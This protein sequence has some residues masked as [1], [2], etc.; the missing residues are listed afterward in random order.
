MKTKIL[1]LGAG[2]TTVWAYRHLLKNCNKSVREN[3]SIEI[4]SVSAE[5]AFH[6]FTGEFL[7]GLL[8]LKLR[9]TSHQTLFPEAHFIQGFVQKVNQI[10]Q[11]VYYFDSKTQ[12]NQVATYDHLVIGMGARDETKSILG[13]KE[14]TFS[15]KDSIGLENIRQRIIQILNTAKTIHDLHFVVCGGGFAGV[16][17]CAN[18]CEYL[19]LLKTHY[20][21]LQEKNYQVHLIQSNETILPQLLP[22]FKNLIAYCECELKNY[23]VKIH[24]NSRVKA[25]KEA[26][27]LLENGVFIESHLVISTIGQVVCAPDSTI[28]F[29]KDAQKRIKGDI[30]LKA[31]G[32]EN[33]WVGGDVAN[34]P[35]I[36]GNGSC[37]ADALW[38]IKH[39]TWIGQNIARTLQQQSLKK[40]TFYGLGQTAS[41]G[42]NKAFS[43]LYGICL[44]GRFAWWVRFFF[45]LYFMPSR[46][47][48][49]QTFKYLW[50]G[51]RQLFPEKKQNSVIKINALDLKL[52]KSYSELL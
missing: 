31:I 41:L 45:F 15:V 8:P 13:T 29:Q 50:R 43:E 39:G 44:T 48:A 51:K 12:S 18:L 17:L 37:R 26:G 52:S 40:F 42:M 2:Y 35:H 36:S 20:P 25:F 30:N 21:I 33:I 10:E 16:E 19:E 14:H 6:G 1:L 11:K 34:I 24:L 38:A 27:V 23:N 9:Y 28:P 3:I 46:A 4:I 49:W 47:N 22:N 7:S 32:F 5:H